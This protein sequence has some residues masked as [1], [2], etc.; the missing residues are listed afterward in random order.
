MIFIG[1]KYN[2]D[3][4]EYLSF[5]CPMKYV[6]ENSEV[7]I[8]GVDRKYGYQ[9]SPKRYHY[10][11]ITKSLLAGNRSVTPNSIVLG[12]NKEDLDKK[13]NVEIIESIG[14]EECVRLVCLDET[15]KIKFRIIDGQH[16]IEGFKEAI[17]RADT[18]MTK[19]LEEY[20]A[21]IIVMLLDADHR[22]PEVKV[23]S[24]INSKAKPLKMDLTVLAEYQYTL[25]EQPNDV[26]AIDYCLTTVMSIIQKGELCEPWKNGIVFDVNSTKKVGSVGFK[27]FKESIQPL[28]KNYQEDLANANGQSTYEDKVKILEDMATKMA[29]NITDC[30]KIV[31][32]KWPAIDKR[33]IEDEDSDV[34]ISYSEEYYLQ[35]TMGTTAINSLIVEAFK[36]DNTSGLDIFKEWIET[37]PLSLADWK[38]N[39][40]FAGLSS[41]AGV[42]E[43]KKSIKG[44][45]K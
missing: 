11:K 6:I 19:D 45:R 38:T 18:A 39:G 37:C 8:Y 15:Q 23:F 14:S 26:N 31:F 9:R 29:K 22:L 32:D 10:L 35:K 21:N 17:K 27:A 25:L 13:F 1:I 4:Q 2:Q 5:I 34:Q 16:R 12:L 28:I 40:K 24:D 36:Q 33:W 41:Q 42:A 7:L 44:D 3:L 43:I 20:R 30:W